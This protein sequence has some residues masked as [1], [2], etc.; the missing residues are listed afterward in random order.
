MHLLFSFFAHSIALQN[1]RK[2]DALWN[3][4]N[5]C[6]GGFDVGCPTYF[7]NKQY[8]HD[9]NITEAKKRFFKESEYINLKLRPAQAS[10]QQKYL[11]KRFRRRAGMLRKQ[12]LQIMNEYNGELIED[13]DINPEYQNIL[14]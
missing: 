6:N 12:Q 7:Y 4:D 10:S 3:K 14:S 5:N 1:S 9:L 2:V 8:G 13:T 11:V